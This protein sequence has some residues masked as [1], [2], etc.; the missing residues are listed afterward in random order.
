MKT[1]S[2]TKTIAAV[3]LALGGFAAASA[4]H[5]RSDVF[6]SIGVQGPAPVYVQPAPVYVQPAPVYV[7]PRPVHVAPRHVYVEHQPAYAPRYYGYSGYDDYRRHDGRR[8]GGWERAGWDRGGPWGDMDRDGI[9]NRDD[10]DRDG[11]GVRNRHDRF[12]QNP[13]RY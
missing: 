1:L 9:R 6:F 3:A 8:H 12:P 7:Q 4:A 13:Y 10:W 2:S 5:A 11:D